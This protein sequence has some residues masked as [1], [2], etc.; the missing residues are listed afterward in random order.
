[1]TANDLGTLD[2]LMTELRTEADH[3]EASGNYDV[4]FIGG[5][6]YAAAHIAAKSAT[7][8]DLSATALQD[9]ADAFEADPF[10]DIPDD[11]K[12]IYA[13]GLRMRAKAP[14]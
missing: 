10:P 5:M 13:Q 7:A 2:R 14:R 6:R 8:V 3:L 1:M 11:I 9:A 12:R 4:H